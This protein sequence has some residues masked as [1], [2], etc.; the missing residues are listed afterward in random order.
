MIT[1]EIPES[2]NCSNIK[3]L[4]DQNKFEEEEIND[5]QISVLKKSTANNN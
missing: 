2:W 3:I 4:S 5:L 1:M